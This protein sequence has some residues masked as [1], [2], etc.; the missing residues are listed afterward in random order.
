MQ[1]NKLFGLDGMARRP[2]KIFRIW[3][4]VFIRYIQACCQF[5]FGHFADL[6]KTRGRYSASYCRMSPSG[7]RLSPRSDY[8]TAGSTDFMIFT[9]TSAPTLAIDSPF[10]RIGA[11]GI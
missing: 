7:Y 2:Q 10:R 1:L 11:T 6:G 3:R 9:I 5:S 8:T 4:F